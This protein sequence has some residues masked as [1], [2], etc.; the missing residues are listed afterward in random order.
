MYAQYALPLDFIAAQVGCMLYFVQFTYCSI[1]ETSHVLLACWHFRVQMCISVTLSFGYLAIKYE[2]LWDCLRICFGS[3]L[4]AV[5]TATLC[6]MELYFYFRRQS[7][8]TVIQT[9]LAFRGILRFLLRRRLMLMI[10]CRLAILCPHT[11]FILSSLMLLFVSRSDSSCNL[12]Q[13]HHR[14]EYPTPPSYTC[15]V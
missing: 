10:T 8:V 12:S 14:T 3:L 4:Q 5:F 15:S 11:V 9:L 7:A 2:H 6:V 13:S 1:L